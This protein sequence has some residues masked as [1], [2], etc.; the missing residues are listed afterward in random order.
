MSEEAEPQL[1]EEEIDQCHAVLEQLLADTNQLF[2][3]PE[4][5]RV[6]LMKAAGLLSRPDR[7]EFKRRTKNAKKAAKRKSEGASS[8]KRSARKSV[9]P[10]A[11][12]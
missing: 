10:T 1:S 5:K 11:K 6:A 4:E 9:S 3:M 8:R 7:E 2:E 12:K